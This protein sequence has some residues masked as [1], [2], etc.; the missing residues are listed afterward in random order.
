MTTNL[1]DILAGLALFGAFYG[2]TA[3]IIILIGG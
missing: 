1:T 2:F 3:A